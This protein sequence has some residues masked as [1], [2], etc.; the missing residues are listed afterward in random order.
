MALNHHENDLVHMVT[1]SFY[2]AVDHPYLKLFIGKPEVS[3]SYISS[4]L[5]LFRE[6]DHLEE[7]IHDAVLTTL[8]VQTALDTHERINRHGL[9]SDRI[10]TERQLTVLA[11]DYYSA[12]YYFILSRCKNSKL[13]HS[14]SLGIQNVNEAKM[15][16][17]HNESS[18]TE[19]DY[20]DLLTAYTGIADALAK[21]Y[22]LHE[23]SVTVKDFLLLTA[24]FDEKKRYS[25]NQISL[26]SRYIESR[27]QKR[28]QTATV[29]AGFEKLIDDL[30]DIFKRGDGHH[31]I[32][33]EQ[34][35]LF[36][37]EIHEQCNNCKTYAVEEG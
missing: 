35:P 9:G 22:N 26:A 19:P 24:L 20:E 37:A 4:L 29:D 31:G 14:L 15:N 25:Q 34:H 18:R 21:S 10:R 13:L 7:E 5:F 11:G 17:Y 27:S 1:T 8:L 3:V 28:D 23:R 16:I 6:T 36:F 2:K 30:M 12:L 33:K 32:F